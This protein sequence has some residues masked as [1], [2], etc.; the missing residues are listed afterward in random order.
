MGGQL[1]ERSF[2]ST[3]RRCT[4]C[5]TAI[6]EH[7]SRNR[8]RAQHEENRETP[9]D[10]WRARCPVMWH[11]GFGGRVRETG[12]SKYWYRA[13]IRPY[14]PGS[15]ASVRVCAPGAVGRQQWGR[16]PVWQDRVPKKRMPAA[17]TQQET[18]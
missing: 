10:L 11:A 4:S 2:C 13:L 5:A 9:R 12:R 8:G 17:E 6:G 7:R 3:P 14:L 1:M 18:V 15:V 16:N